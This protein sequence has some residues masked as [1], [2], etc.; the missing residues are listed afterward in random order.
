MGYPTPG[1]SRLVEVV[2]GRHKSNIYSA[3]LGGY[4]GAFWW[5][6]VPAIDGDG[7]TVK[8]M[9]INLVL[10]GEEASAAEISSGRVTIDY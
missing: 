6:R 10:W 2:R 8:I 5:Q 4:S 3:D 7:N 9:K 1:N